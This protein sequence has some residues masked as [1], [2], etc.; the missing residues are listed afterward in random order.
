MIEPFTYLRALMRDFYQAGG[1]IV[2]RDFRNREEIS[3]LPEPVVF[4]CTGLGARDL[5]GDQSLTPVR[6]QLEILL[7][8]PEVDY[9]YLGSRR[10]VASRKSGT[11]HQN[12]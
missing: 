12:S 7:P 1:K 8:Q 10:L 5:F 9:C 3:R 6:G 11:H 4:N 2:V